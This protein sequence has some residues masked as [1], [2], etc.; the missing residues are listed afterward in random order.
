MTELR[1]SDTPTKVIQRYLIVWYWSYFG[2]KKSM[3]YTKK[4]FHDL[5]WPPQNIIP[6]LSR[7]WLKKVLFSMIF[8]T[9]WTLWFRS[10]MRYVSYIKLRTPLMPCTVTPKP[11]PC[12]MPPTFACV[13]FLQEKEKKRVLFFEN[14][15]S[16][17]RYMEHLF[18][19]FSLYHLQGL[20]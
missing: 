18:P 16:N 1:P 12:Y 2:D 10:F 20:F 11:L 4:R 19:R 17:Y 6:G 8:Q 14:I 5:P 3:D 13:Y 7:P 15:Y 9:V